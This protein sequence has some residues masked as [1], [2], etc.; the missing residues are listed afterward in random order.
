MKQRAAHVAT[1]RHG[2]LGAVVDGKNC[3]ADLRD[4]HEQH[5]RAVRPDIAGVAG[6]HS[7]IDDVGVER[8]Q[9][10]GRDRLGGLQRHDHN[11]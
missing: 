7:A 6:C 11:Q 5:H 3:E 2:D 1:E 4:A 8:R 10:Q 9:E